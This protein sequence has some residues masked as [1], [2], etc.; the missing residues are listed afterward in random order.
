MRLIFFGNPRFAVPSLE[1][2][3]SS[4]HD[5]ACVVTSQDRPAGRGRKLRVPDVK[6]AAE[7][8]GLPVTQVEDLRNASF[9]EKIAGYAAL[10]FVVVAFRILPPELFSIP[11]NGAVNLHASLLPKYRGAAPINRAIMAGET[12]T[13]VTTF[14]IER[15]VDTGGILLQYSEPILPD[16][17]F[18]SL[19]DRLSVLGADALVETLDGLESGSLQQKPQDASTATRAPKLKPEDAEIDWSK[20]AEVIRNQIRGLC[21]T[22]GAFTYLNGTKLKIFAGEVIEQPVEG[23]NPGKITGSNG[24]AGLLVA[25][26]SGML[27][28]LDLQ[29]SGKRR[30]RAEDF[31]RGHPISAGEQL[32]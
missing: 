17:T 7:R 14:Q 23:M 25:C 10:L 31:L 13:G 5:V 2:L 11:Q 19:H 21:S 12:E 6:L 32:G 15:R 20:S 30:M 1:R 29:P 8:L 9:L 4:S 18:D 27:R 24:S 16:D 26:G 28:I 3:A 22:P